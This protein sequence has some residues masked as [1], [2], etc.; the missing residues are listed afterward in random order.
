M[1]VRYLISKISLI[2]VI[3]SF[4]ISLLPVFAI[5]QTESIELDATYSRLESNMLGGGG[6]EFTVTLRYQG[7]ESRNFYLQ[8]V[9]PAGWTTYI[10]PGYGITRITAIKQ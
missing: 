4:V 1:G 2:F 3:F 6:F 8:T 9:A 7:H 10:T 5:A